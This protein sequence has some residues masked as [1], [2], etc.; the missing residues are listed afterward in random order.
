MCGINTIL[1]STIDSRGQDNPKQF[2]L[3]GSENTLGSH[4]YGFK[5]PEWLES[6]LLITDLKH[7][8]TG[9]NLRLDLPGATIVIDPHLSEIP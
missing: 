7:F 2:R 5:L 6:P 1:V 8:K 4:Y 9:N 3:P